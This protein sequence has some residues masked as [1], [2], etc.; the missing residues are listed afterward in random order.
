VIVAHR[1]L[2][3]GTLFGISGIAWL[4]LWWWAQS[5]YGR[6]IDH[7]DWTN[8]GIAGSICA[9]LPAGEFLLPAFLYTGGWLL[10]L[11]AM[12]LPTILPL[13]EIYRRI[14]DK[15]TDRNRLL[16]MVI[17]GYLAVWMVFAV[18]A[19]SADLSLREIAKSS[20]WLT[21]N[22]WAIGVGVIALAGAFQFTDLKKRC[23]EQCRTPMS[24]IMKHWSR[25]TDGPTFAFRLGWGHGLFCVGCCWATMLLMFIVGTANVGWMLLLGAVM[26]FEKN[27]PWGKYITAPF[28]AGLMLCAL[29]ILVWN[30][31]LLLA[32]EK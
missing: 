8:I 12:M 25:R 1:K 22:G 27:L 15:R 16:F 24:F 18:L 13:L 19:H 10:M 6:Y 32:S 4:T 29:G 2:F 5:P 9:T 31:P 21:F 14:T 3:A 30:S 11:I 26:A 28:G 20:P 17:S 23:L 7:G